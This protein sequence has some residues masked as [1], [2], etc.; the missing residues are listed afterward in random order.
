M[1]NQ[2]RTTARDMADFIAKS[3][4]PFH[5]IAN[6]KSF[7]SGH[8]LVSLPEMSSRWALVPGKTYCVVRNGS[9]AVFFHIPDLPVSK[10]DISF[11]IAAAHTDSP[12]LK[13]KNNP[14][15]V[16]DG[17]ARLN[18]EGYGGLMRNS[19]FDRPLSLAGRVC[20]MDDE[21]RTELVDFGETLEVSI[22][23]LAVHMGTT[24]E[25]PSIQRHMLPIVGTAA[26]DGELSFNRLLQDVLA[27]E[28]ITVKLS[29]ILSYDIIAYNAQEASLWGFDDEMLSSPRLDDQACVYTALIGFS[30]AIDDISANGESAHIPVLVLFDNEEEGSST[31]QGADSS[32]LY[33]V[34]SRVC[35]GLGLDPGQKRAAV[36]RSFMVSADNA[37]G[38][39]PAYPEKADPTNRPHLNGG[40]VIK[41]AANQKYCTDAVSAAR[42]KKLC[43]DRD[44]PFQDYYNNSDVRG[45]STLGNISARHVSISGADIGIAQ[46]AMHSA[47][48]CCGVSDISAMGMFFREFFTGR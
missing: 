24:D 11:E 35:Q 29:D 4:T 2:A 3:P 38:V 17:Y 26:K 33:D 6:A 32:F 18:V 22:P 13:V 1:D 41:H 36:A 8:G 46:L 16:S 30:E 37:H 34:L 40:I 14:V 21:I 27:K 25:T 47:Y 15:I 42:I 23:S 9:A 19:W 20:F 39:H 7:L 45:G 48:E 5:V 12:A 44:I 43:L 28:G 10:N 31:K